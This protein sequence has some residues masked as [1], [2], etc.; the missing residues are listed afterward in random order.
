MTLRELIAQLQELVDH[1]TDPESIIL[2]YDGEDGMWMP[3][4]GLGFG[5]GSVDIYTDS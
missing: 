2:A 5:E 4:T 3:V 1:G